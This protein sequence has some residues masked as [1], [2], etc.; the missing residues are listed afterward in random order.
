[1]LKLNQTWHVE[2][3]M[4]VEGRTKRITSIACLWDNLALKRIFAVKSKN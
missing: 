4:Y 2:F 1:M 3:Q